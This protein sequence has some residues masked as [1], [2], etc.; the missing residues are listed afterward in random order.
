MKLP[1]FIC[2]LFVVLAAFGLLFPKI[3]SAA[4][5]EQPDFVSVRLAAEQ[6]DAVALD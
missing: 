3:P 2:L 5:E 1:F 4:Q 6:G